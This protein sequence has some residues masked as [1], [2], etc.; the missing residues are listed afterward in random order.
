MVEGAGQWQSGGVQNCARG[1]AG[2]A[3]WFNSESVFA[4]QCVLAESV[5][6]VPLLCTCQAWR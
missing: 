2:E 4:L 3:A 5:R 6:A 1:R